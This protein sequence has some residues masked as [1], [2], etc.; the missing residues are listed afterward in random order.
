MDVN[1]LRKILFENVTN[2]IEMQRKEDALIKSL[3]VD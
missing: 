1:T 3:R 2:R